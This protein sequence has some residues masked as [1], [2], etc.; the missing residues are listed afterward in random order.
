MPAQH[1]QIG[2]GGGCHWCTEAVYNSLAGVHEV[3]QGYI[4]SLPPHEQFSEAVL[5]T[6]DE[7]QISLKVLIEIHIRTHASSSSHSMR[8]KYRS[9]IYVGDNAL[10]NRCESILEFLQARIDKPLVTQVPMR[11]F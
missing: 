3:R 6:F 10:K 1:L 11:F 9:A 7:E 5:A 4:S 8:E 2:F